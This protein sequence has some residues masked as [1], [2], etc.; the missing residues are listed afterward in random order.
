MFVSINRGYDYVFVSEF[1][2][3]VFFMWHVKSETSWQWADICI[4]I[5]CYLY[6]YGYSEVMKAYNLSFSDSSM[7]MYLK[8]FDASNYNTIIINRRRAVLEVLVILWD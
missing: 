2:S 4:D 3:F 7:S 8:T 6:A 5:S 1:Y